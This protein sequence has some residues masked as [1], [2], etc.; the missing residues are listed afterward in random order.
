MVIA[1]NECGADTCSFN[2]VVNDAEAPVITCANAV[3]VNNSPGLCSGTT[4]LTLPDV[5]DNC[6]RTPDHALN[7]DGIDDYCTSAATLTQND[8]F[9][10]EVRALYKGHLDYYQTL[11]GFSHTVEIMGYDGKIH[12]LVNNSSG[13]LVPEFNLVDGQWYH[14]ALVRRLGVWEFY[15]DGVS[16]PIQ[17]KPAPDLGGT[18]LIGGRTNSLVRWKGALDEVR[19][20]TVARTQAEIQTNMNSTLSAQTGLRLL[21]HADQG[22]AEGEIMQGKQPVHLSENGYHATLNNFALN[23]STSSKFGFLWGVWRLYN[24]QLPATHNF[25]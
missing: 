2:V 19:V 21:Y 1:T 16:Y 10:L 13:Y 7:F 23:G 14:F 20:W 11:I 25:W 5:T 8:N 22:A 9:T 3:T 17:Q 12:Y 24:Q 18:F 6:T 4:I 15:I